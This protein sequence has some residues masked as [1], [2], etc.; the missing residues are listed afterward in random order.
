MPIFQPKK[1]S[2]DFLR[3]FFSNVINY[4]ISQIHD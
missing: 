2:K 1:Y 4:F 3:I